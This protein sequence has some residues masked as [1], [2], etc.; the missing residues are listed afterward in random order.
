LSA[1][2]QSINQ[3]IAQI[4]AEELRNATNRKRR[5]RAKKGTLI[6]IKPTKHW[7]FPNPYQIVEV[8]PKDA[9]LTYTCSDGA[10]KSSE[11]RKQ[12]PEN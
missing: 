11:G 1:A 7:Y 2:G 3:N 12:N 5:I 10:F 6:H 9:R 4:V 8:E